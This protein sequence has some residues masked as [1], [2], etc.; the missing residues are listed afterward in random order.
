MISIIL[1]WGYHHIPAWPLHPVGFGVVTTF[2]ADMAFFSIFTIWLVKSLIM[3]FGGVTL[4]RTAQPF[5]IGILCGYTI[6]VLLSFAADYFW[7]PGAGH[8]VDD[9]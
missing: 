2:A 8:V 7:F 6:G 5:F 4:Y 9:W 1:I 3:R